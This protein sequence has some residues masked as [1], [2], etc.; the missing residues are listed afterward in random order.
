MALMLNFWVGEAEHGGGSRVGNVRS[1]AAEISAL[2]SFQ[3][4]EEVYLWGRIRSARGLVDLW[5]LGW[6]LPT[7]YDEKFTLLRWFPF[8][9]PMFE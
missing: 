5:G 1:V 8:S 4:V 2:P 9:D 6:S 7:T 3:G